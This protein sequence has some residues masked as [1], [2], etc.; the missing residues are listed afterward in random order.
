MPV[1]ALIF[2]MDGLMVDTEPI[3]WK[4]TRELAKKC[5]T[6]VADST[7]RRMMGRS[8]MEA[9][10]FFA[11]ECGITAVSP[12]GLLIEREQMMI[13]RYA[14]GVETLPGLR[15]IIDRF[16][17]VLASFDVDLPR[18]ERGVV[19][20]IHR[21][22]SSL[23]AE[24]PRQLAERL[25]RVEQSGGR[26]RAG[27]NAGWRYRQPVAFRPIPLGGRRRAKESIA[28]H[29]SVDA[30]WSVL[31][32]LDHG[33]DSVQGVAEHSTARLV[34]GPGRNSDCQR[35]AA[36]NKLPLPEIEPL[37]LRSQVRNKSR[38]AGRRGPGQRGIAHERRHQ[39][40]H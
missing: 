19:N 4:V 3:Y 25:R 27:G 7:L 39:G 29:E 16:R 33:A 13:A 12:A 31:P 8:A 2:D 15:Q 10:C 40:R 35:C 5:G 1:R 17:D 32:S 36:E 23:L 21:R 30:V 37:R 18:L 14:A 20:D 38:A 6:T 22:Q 24:D 11:G 28:D 26:V 34:L 9:M